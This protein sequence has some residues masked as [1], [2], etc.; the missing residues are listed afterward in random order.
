L[1]SPGQLEDLVSSVD[2]NPS[3]GIVYVTGSTLGNLGASVRIGGRDAYIARF[4]LTNGDQVGNIQHIGSVGDDFGYSIVVDN[5]RSTVYTAGS[6][7]N[8]SMNGVSPVGNAT[9]QF[10]TAY[11]LSL[12]HIWT[13]I[14]GSTGFNDAAFSIAIHPSSGNI[15]V[16]GSHDG[17][18]IPAVN[19][20]STF[21]GQS[22]FSLSA[23]AVNNSLLWTRVGGSAS[24]DLARSCAFNSNG[25]LYMAGKFDASISMIS[26]QTDR[27]DSLASVNVQPWP[28]CYNNLW[29][30]TFLSSF[31]QTV[32]QTITVMSVNTIISSVTTTQTTIIIQQSSVTVTPTGLDSQGS[33]NNAAAEAAANGDIILTV[34]I[35]LTSACVILTGGLV[36]FVVLR[37]KKD[38]ESAVFRTPYRNTESFYPD[39]FRRNNSVLSEADKLFTATAITDNTGN[40]QAYITTDLQTKS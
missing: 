9:D 2:S 36:V 40:V 30:V 17:S 18:M 22:D 26:F 6:V 39:V 8:S 16:A 27:N 5:A 21:Y 31:T 13:R 10:V 3:S 24:A 34:G 28:T 19:V 15:Y 11:S 25:S 23:M 35:A 33:S 4:N 7:G 12:A 38:N 14:I 37:R 29:T 20:Q 32:N 1:S